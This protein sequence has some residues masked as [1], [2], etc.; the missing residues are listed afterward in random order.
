MD[1]AADFNDGKALK[2]KPKSALAN[3][4]TYNWRVCEGGLG[5][6]VCWEENL[7]GS[8]Q[9]KQSKMSDKSKRWGATEE[10]RRSNA[11]R[12]WQVADDARAAR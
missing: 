6:R 12:R 3:Q 8:G 5:L 1:K 9:R 7:L 4:L 10:A 11:E 2:I